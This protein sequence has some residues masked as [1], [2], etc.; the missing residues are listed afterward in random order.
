M[1]SGPYEPIHS[2]DSADTATTL[3]AVDLYDGPQNN[4]LWSITQGALDLFFSQS[5]ENWKSDSPRIP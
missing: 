3:L 4:D 2:L 5:S 1:C